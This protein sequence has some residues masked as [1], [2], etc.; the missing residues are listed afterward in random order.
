MV[1]RHLVFCGWN[2][3]E[4]KPPFVH[5]QAFEELGDKIEGDPEFGVVEKDEVTSAVTAVSSGSPTD[6]A[7]IQLLAQRSASNR[8]SQW[9]PRER[10]GPL[11][12]Q[13]DQDPAT[14]A[15]EQPLISVPAPTPPARSA[16]V[17][18]KVPIAR[19]QPNRPGRPWDPPLL[20]LSIPLVGTLPVAKTKT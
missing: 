9:R 6:P 16:V 5:D 17:S 10:L 12:L 1:S 20:S 15:G 2:S 4:A 18:S 3:L 13:D 11:P 7:K 14:G 19:R 8:P